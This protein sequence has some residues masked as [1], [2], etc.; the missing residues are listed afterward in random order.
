MGRVRRELAL[1][2]NDFWFAAGEGVSACSTGDT[3]RAPAAAVQRACM[4][5]R[6]KHWPFLPGRVLGEMDSS[7]FG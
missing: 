7:S 4:V 5:F 6:E 1:S 2:K 3:P